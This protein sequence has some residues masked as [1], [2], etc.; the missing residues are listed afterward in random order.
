MAEENEFAIQLMTAQHR[1][2][3]EEEP[4][5]PTEYQHECG[6]VSRHRG[7]AGGLGTSYF[8]EQH[9][10]RNPE[11]RADD[12]RRHI[13]QVCVAGGFIELRQFDCGREQQAQKHGPEQ[14]RPALTQNQLRYQPQRNIEADIDDDVAEKKTARRGVPGVQEDAKRITRK[15]PRREVPR[16]QRSVDDQDDGEDKNAA[17]ISMV[18]CA[19]GYAGKF[20]SKLLEGKTAVIAGVAN[21]WSLAFAIAESFAREGATIILTYVNEKQRDTVESMVGSMSIAKMLP[22]DVTSDEEIDALAERLREFGKP[23]DVLVHSLAFANR[24][25]LNGSFANTQRDGFLLAQNVSAYSLV[26]MSRAVAPLM[27]NGGSIMTMTYIGATRAV[28]NYNVMGVAKA[29]LEASMRYL[30]RDLGPQGIRVNAISAGAVKTA[31]A[32]AVKD[33]MTM[34]DAVKERSPLRHATEP[35]EVGDTAVFLASDLSRGVTGNIV[36]VD[37][38]MQLL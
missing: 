27:T 19:S 2:E 18:A 28:P 8:F 38:G 21:K 20:M 15:L 11:N 34:L 26:A 36:F 32:R 10:D 29:S 24:D 16:V 1:E 22:C 30:A 25:D 4:C 13:D 37:S 35:G 17:Q 5:G 3:R 7:R 14:R 9:G 23:I 31:S 6:A 33:L 12:V